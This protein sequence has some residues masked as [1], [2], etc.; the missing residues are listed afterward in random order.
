MSLSLIR[1]PLGRI[2]I[3]DFVYIPRKFSS[4]PKLF[5]L[6]TKKYLHHHPVDC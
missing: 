3:L 6:K 5:P 1:R 2:F 4:D